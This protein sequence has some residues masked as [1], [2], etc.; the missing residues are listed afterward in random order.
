MT[1]RRADHGQP[2]EEGPD[3]Y[4]WPGLDAEFTERVAA[5]AATAEG[6]ELAGSVV[7]RQGDALRVGHQGVPLR[8]RPGVRA[9]LTALV[10]AYHRLIETIVA[11]YGRDRR[12]REVLT[13][14]E[15][16]RGEAAAARDDRVHLLRLDLLPQSDGTVRI[17]ET[18]AN[19]PGGLHVSGQGRAAWRPLL[20]RH[21]ID[22][23]APLPS[24]AGDWLGR[25]FLDTA[26]RHTGRRPHT[27]AV[28][29]PEGANRTE[30]PEYGEALTALGARVLH[31]DPR[32][33]D[34]GPDGGAVLRGEEVR[35]AYAKIGMQDLARLSG[36]V[37][38]YLR[39]VREGA[40]FV[41]NGVR[42]RLVGDNKLCLA[43]LSDPAFA[44]L[45]GPADH[46][47]VRPA[48]PWSRNLARCDDATVRA[49]ARDRERYV[50][51]RP[52]D[53]RGRGVV[54][55]RES[56]DAAWREAVDRAGAEGWLVQEYLPSPRLRTA[57]DGPALR[58]D[59]ALGAV[60]GRLA[61]AF[62]RTGDGERLNVARSGCPHSVYL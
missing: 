40:L 7:F 34:T 6:R 22:L 50:L 37:G 11:A 21:G 54:I 10:A 28:L 35:Y 3:G 53:T 45:F 29:C 38:P 32:E 52:L 2:A 39:A 16:L 41:Q 27:V 31:A 23:P 19:C 42:G 61:A 24:E 48:V 17:L 46:R 26:E 62:V 59:L 47:R 30:V 57:P 9:E 55:G 20:S 33:L 5:L 15:P 58:H 44:D 8:L 51:K 25:W 36:E 12:L 43:V 49:V 56:D 18:N 60:D 13:L 14:P 1:S 4:T